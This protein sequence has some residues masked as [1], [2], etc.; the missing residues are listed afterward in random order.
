MI[1]K[2]TRRFVSR[3]GPYHAVSIV[4]QR[5]A[6][7]AAKALVNKRFLINKAPIVP[8]PGCDVDSCECMYSHYEDRREGERRV[9]RSCGGFNAHISNRRAGRDRRKN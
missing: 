2:R 3:L 4:P 5:T 8:L 1:I 6:C 7:K 9:Q